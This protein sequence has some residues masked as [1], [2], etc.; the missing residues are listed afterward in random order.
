MVL[1]VIC[2]IQKNG[3]TLM[4]HRTKKAN[5]IHE[6]K[7]NGVGGK[8]EKNEC[9]EEAVK[10][11]VFEESGLKIKKPVLKGII[12]YPDSNNGCGEWFV[13]VFI[14]K[15]FSG[16]LIDCNEGDL[17]WIPNKQLLKLKMWKGD[18]LFLPLLKKKGFF[19]GKILYDKEKIVEKKFYHY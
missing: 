2:Y 5:D 17:K 9:P 13:F 14:A 11:E 19:T 10:R 4:L 18:Y 15:N 6:G 16:K 12:H 8:I 7:W 1:S 3:K